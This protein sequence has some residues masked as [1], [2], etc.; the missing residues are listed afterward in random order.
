MTVALRQ[1]FAVILLVV[2]L[3]VVLGI[4]AAGC[5]VASETRAITS[6]TEIVEP[7]LSGSTTPLGRL[8]YGDIPAAGIQLLEASGG[9]GMTG[10]PVP[11]FFKVLG[12]KGENPAAHEAIANTLLALAEKNKQA[13]FFDTVQVVV[14]TSAGEILYDH[15]FQVAPP[16]STSST[17]RGFM[18]YYSGPV[19]DVK[20]RQGVHLA[21]SVSRGSDGTTIVI[22]VAMENHSSSAFTLSWGDVRFYV[23]GVRLE[24]DLDGQELPD[25]SPVAAGGTDS[26]GLYF[27][28]PDF[29]PYAAG[30]QYVSSDPSSAGF[31][32]SDGQVPATSP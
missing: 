25:R 15:T 26:A 31:T 27:T 29:D 30:L 19:L 13:L 9:P 20:P 1:A 23:D 7:P 2:S 8:V 3:A 17:T 5:G 14:A 11:L 32:A 28:V 6:V 21:V 12:T 18:T 16:E 24:M 22:S 10:R 4:F